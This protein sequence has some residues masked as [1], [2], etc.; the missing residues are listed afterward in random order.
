MVTSVKDYMRTLILFIMRDNGVNI[1]TSTSCILSACSLLTI[2]P[3]RSQCIYLDVSKYFSIQVEHG[4]LMLP[5]ILFFEELK[6]N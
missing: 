5:R 2:F 3:D 6:Q 4:T 1:V